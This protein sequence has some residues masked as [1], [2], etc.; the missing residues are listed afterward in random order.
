MLLEDKV[1]IIV[2][3][4]QERDDQPP[5]RRKMGTASDVVWAAAFLAS[6]KAGFIAGIS[7][8]VDSGVS[9]A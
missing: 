1:A 7:L 8:P 4:G 9:V 3:G 6:D 2:G 5:L